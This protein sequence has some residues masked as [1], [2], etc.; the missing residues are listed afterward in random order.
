MNTSVPIVEYLELGNS[1]HLVAQ[2]CASCQATYFDR[3]DAC[4]SCFGST[5]S[6]V[7]VS[8]TGTLETFTIVAVAAPGINVPFVAGVVDCDGVA[9]RSTIVNVDPTPKEVR[10]GMPLRLTTF[11][12]GADD[13]GTEAIGFGFEPVDNG[14]DTK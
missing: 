8:T 6:P 14:K 1:P 11:A 4:A 12:L 2:Q 7:D 10:M 3:R 9:V 13:N 5:F